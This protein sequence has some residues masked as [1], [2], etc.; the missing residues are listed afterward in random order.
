MV[1]RSLD[2]SR[3]GFYYKNLNKLNQDNIK[4]LTLRRRGKML[5]K[6]WKK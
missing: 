4:F 1:A 2:G 6:S 3:A 5:L